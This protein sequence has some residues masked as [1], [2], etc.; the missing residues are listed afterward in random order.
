ME[1]LATALQ[2]QDHMSRL[3]IDGAMTLVASDFQHIGPDG[4]A[5]DASELRGLFAG[6][7]RMMAN[8]MTMELVGSTVQGDRVALE[9]TGEARLA[10][11]NT[12]RNRY[13]FLFVI[14]GGLIHRIH[15]Y[16]DITALQAFS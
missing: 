5:L 9:M 1:N 11:G 8:G 10:N 12:Y 15:E 6:L 4:N 2:F 14:N 13:H 3:D 16:C 7:G